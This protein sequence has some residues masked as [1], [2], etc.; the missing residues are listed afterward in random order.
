[1]VHIRVD[2]DGIPV[3]A[4]SDFSAAGISAATAGLRAFAQ[5]AAV[6]ADAAYTAQYNKAYND[7]VQNKIDEARDLIDN[8]SG[9][10]DDGFIDDLQEV[11]AV[12]GDDTKTD[13]TKTDDTK[14]DDN[15]GTDNQN[16]QKDDSGKEPGNQTPGKGVAVLRDVDDTEGTSALKDLIAAGG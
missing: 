4:G 16:G 9:E 13:D 8:H 15:K 3:E 6:T 5:A 7:A 12:L 14:T 10:Y 1:M 11:L 2:P